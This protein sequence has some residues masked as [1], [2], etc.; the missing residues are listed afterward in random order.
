MQATYKIPGTA[1]L[2]GYLR[3][4]PTVYSCIFT[5]APMLTAQGEHAIYHHGC[6]AANSHNSG[7]VVERHWLATIFRFL[8]L[9]SR[10]LSS[11]FRGT[12]ALVLGIS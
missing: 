7:G 10:R 1:L 9:A 2:I 8:P 12:M 5:R 3:S 4:R 11:S 6:T